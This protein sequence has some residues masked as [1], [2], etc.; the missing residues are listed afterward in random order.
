MVWVQSLAQELLHAEGAAKKK[1]KILKHAWYADRT[2]HSW[3]KGKDRQYGTEP[4]EELA[5][6]KDLE[7]E[8]G[9]RRV[10]S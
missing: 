1:K 2:D 6:G 5:E 3:G 8:S 10:G 9:V 7:M 4:A